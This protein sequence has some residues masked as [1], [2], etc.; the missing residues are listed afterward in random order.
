MK[1]RF[2][3]FVALVERLRR[4][5]PWDR[6]Q[7]HESIRESIIEE[8]YEV[9]DAIDRADYQ[10]LKVELGD[11]LLNVVFHAV[12]AKEADAFAIEDVLES[13]TAKLVARHPHVF[14]NE[15][16]HE[17]ESVLKNWERIK[18]E[19]EGRE[20]VLDGIPPALPALQFAHRVQSKAARVGFDFA[21]PDDAWSKVTEELD[22]IDR[23][24]DGE[25]DDLAGEIGDLLFAIVNYA[26]LRGL[27]AETAL[28]RTNSKFADR[29]RFIERALENEGR[30][31][32]TASLEEMDSLW[33]EAKRREDD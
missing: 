8:A 25:E 18:R 7:T 1:G 3:E 5:C 15:E 17:Q 13:E 16:A 31:P 12:M 19:Q 29:F 26:R 24:R 6:N 9:V 11:V 21:T 32:D 22:E 20:S 23:I 4:E 14:G 33:D 2:E 27:S 30:S 28:R 10:D